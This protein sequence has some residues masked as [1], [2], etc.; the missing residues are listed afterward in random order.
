MQHTCKAADELAIAIVRG[1]TGTDDSLTEML[2]VGTV[3]GTIE[4]RRLITP[5]NAKTGDLFLCTK[6]LGLERGH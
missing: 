5:D 3:Y 2:G 1:H 4:P 6:P